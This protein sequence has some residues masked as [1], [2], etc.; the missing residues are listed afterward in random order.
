MTFNSLPD[1]KACG[2]MKIQESVNWIWRGPS[3]FRDAVAKVKKGLRRRGR[4]AALPEPGRVQ[5]P[6][7]LLQR[8]LLGLLAPPRA[9]LLRR[10][11][12]LGTPVG[13]VSRVRESASSAAEPRAAERAN[14]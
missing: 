13:G 8:G 6:F 14:L 10:R 12:A 11:D 1:D 4:H 5:L 7:L 3:G 9:L 2:A